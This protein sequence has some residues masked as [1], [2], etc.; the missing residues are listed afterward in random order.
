MYLQI[1]LLLDVFIIGALST[2]AI[3][4]ALA[5]YRPAKPAAEDKTAA[6]SSQVQLPHD[7]KEKLLRTSQAN[8]QKVLDRSA[9]ELQEE[10]ETTGTNLN[11]ALQR[12][13]GEIVGNELERYRIN[14]AKIRQE[15][16][17][18]IASAQT[19]LSKHQAQLQELITQEA[20][21]MQV[22]LNSEMAVEKDRLIKQ[23]DTKLGDAVASFLLDALQHNIDLGA[24]HQF[25]VNLLEEHKDEFTKEVADEAPAAK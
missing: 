19:D 2:I 14:L 1:F 3:Q 17:V 16:E 21:K 7:I 24:Q 4:H 13:G 18:S 5:H 10:L 6:P 8:F 25:L 9:D 11:T 23:I 22:Q 15:S 20:A 12:L